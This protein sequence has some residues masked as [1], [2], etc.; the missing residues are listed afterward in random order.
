MNTLL[1]A[2]LLASPAFQPVR[3]CADLPPLRWETWLYRD[4]GEGLFTQEAFL[5]ETEWRAPEDDVTGA[6]LVAE[7]FG[8]PRPHSRDVVVHHYPPAPLTPP[9]TRPVLLVTGAG[10]N[11]LRSM[12]FLAVALSRR[13]FHAYALT[14]AHRHGDNFQ[15]AEQVANAV[16]LLG[17]R[18]P[19]VKADVVAYSKGGVA[20]RI[21]A[22]NTAEASWRETHPAYHTH[23]TRYRGDV[24]RLILLGVP[25][26]GLDT[27]FRWPSS[28]LLSLNDPP[29]DAPVSW[30]A[31]YPNTTANPLTRVDLAA[32]SLFRAG[33]DHFPGQAQLLADLRGL[34]PLPGGNPALGLYANQPDYFTTYEGGLGFV[35]ESP[36]IARAIEE[37]GG[38]IAALQREGVAPEVEL[39][40]AAGGNPIMS[41]G[42]LNADVFRAL[43][44]D[45]D[46]ARRRSAWEGLVE[47]WLG[48]LFPWWSEAFEH[49]LPRLFGG[50]AFLGEVSG[51]SD[52]LLF[53]DSAL[54]ASG[55]TRRGAEV[56]ESRL[57]PGLNHAELVAAGELAADFYGDPELAGGFYDEQLA[58]KYHRGEN[59]VVEWVARTLEEPV[60]EEPLPPDAGVSEA[61]GGAPDGGP[62]AAPDATPEGDA[63][64]PTDAAAPAPADVGVPLV[65]AARDAAATGPPGDGGPPAGDRFGGSCR[66]SPP[67]G[68][69]PALLLLLLPVLTRRRRG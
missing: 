46:A 32:R 35:S 51:P 42:S 68:A 52:G 15:Q 17:R 9:R 24:G 25:N 23:G 40:L 20:A 61:D 34:H 36:G 45:L 63:E 48:D 22:S 37:S 11:A 26:A 50:T 54:D 38:T 67:A 64:A 29:P 16:A 13:G 65:D 6:R 19:G 69:P 47:S 66:L 12:S 28:N 59:Q 8:S 56:V 7:C 21:Y 44:G 43:W 58:A 39:Y 10:D 3:D 55:L 30:V 31:Y 33:G 62:D 60:P 53:V 1:L 18:H 41:V 2:T 14:F 49:D 4:A 27:S 5:P 57:F